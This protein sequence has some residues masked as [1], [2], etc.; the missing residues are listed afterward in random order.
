M[1]VDWRGGCGG[2]E[3]LVGKAICSLWRRDG[4]ET[5]CRIERGEDPL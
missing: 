5:V 1:L 2:W 3:M 4:G